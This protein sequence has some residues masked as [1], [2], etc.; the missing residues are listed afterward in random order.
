MLFRSIPDDVSSE[1]VRYSAGIYYTTDL[2]GCTLEQMSK[3]PIYSHVPIKKLYYW[4]SHDKWHER[5][6]ALREQWRKII[7]SRIGNELAK[8]RASQL[9]AMNR[10]YQVALNKLEGNL[11][12]AKSWEGVLVAFVRLTEVMEEFREKLARDLPAA[13]AGLPAPIRP[14]L[15]KEEIREAALMIVKKRMEQAEQVAL[16]PAEEPDDGGSEEVDE[17][18]GAQFVAGGGGV[19]SGV[20]AK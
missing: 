11:V 9:E 3:H 14:K 4:F 19:R 7:E 12:Q 16:G 10:V 17:E 2:G 20:V 6:A 13:G 5:R 1:Y 15:N 18:G 8:A